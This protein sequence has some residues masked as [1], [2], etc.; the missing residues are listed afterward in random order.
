MPPSAPS[1]LVQFHLAVV[2][3]S[4]C[5]GL[6][7]ATRRYGPLPPLIESWTRQQEGQLA[8]R[9]WL[10]DT[11]GMA[12]WLLG[13]QEQQLKISEEKLLQEAQRI[14][15]EESQLLDRY[16]WAV[17]LMLHHE[18]GLHHRNVASHHGLKINH[19]FSHSLCA[20][21]R[22]LRDRQALRERDMLSDRE[23]DRLSDRP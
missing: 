8:G 6:P 11:E 18:L 3:C 20:Q 21:V 14:L 10:W 15:G 16:R 22:P 9:K 17:D 5:N 7:E 1:A 12:E 23:T 13:Q 2:L 4:L 19:R